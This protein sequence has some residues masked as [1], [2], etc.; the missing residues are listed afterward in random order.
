MQGVRL[1]LKPEGSEG[2]VVWL[3]GAEH[4][5][6]MGQRVQREHEHLVCS[7]N[8][9]EISVARA[10]QVRGSSRKWGLE[11]ADGTGSVGIV[12]TSALTVNETE[13]HW[14]AAVLGLDW[15]GQGWRRQ[16]WIGDTHQEA[17]PVIQVRNNST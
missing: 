17:T 7:R 12:R 2:V 11:G 3:S 4:S 6:Q 15:R 14:K 1:A 9:Q 10:K 16:G 5:R 13:S 8:N